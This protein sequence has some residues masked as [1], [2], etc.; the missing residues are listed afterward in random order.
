MKFYLLG[1]AIA[2]VVYG[3]VILARELKTH[4][5][6]PLREKGIVVAKQFSPDTRQT[7]MGTGMS[8][9]GELIITSHSVGDDQK[10]NIVFKCDHGVLFT[11]NQ[12]EVYAKLKEGDTVIIDY[13]ELLNRKDAVRDYEF[14]DANKFSPAAGWLRSSDFE[15]LKK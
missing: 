8:S 1:I 14:I 15:S 10:F 6:K 5:S 9:S 4:K 12:P 7:V 11:I 13:Y 3:I 2:L